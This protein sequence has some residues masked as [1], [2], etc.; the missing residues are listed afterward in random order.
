MGTFDTTRSAQRD[1]QRG[2]LAPM[3]TRPPPRPCVDTTRTNRCATGER[4]VG[5][6]SPVTVLVVVAVVV[7]LLVDV[8]VVTLGAVVVGFD[9]VVVTLGAVVV[10][11]T[12]VWTRANVAVTLR[13]VMLM[14]TLQLAPE[15][16]QSPF[17]PENV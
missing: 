2:P 3:A 16:L 1:V 11:F 7:V 8:V 14:A 6:C 17:H 4:V 5:F 10:G 13:P 15:P 12:G 9:V